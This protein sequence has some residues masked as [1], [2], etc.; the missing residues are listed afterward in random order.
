M[1]WFKRLF[2]AGHAT[3]KTHPSP[4]LAPQQPD[5]PVKPR[6]AHAQ[7]SVDVRRHFYNETG[8]Q[9]YGSFFRLWEGWATAGHVLS[10]ASNLLP[11]FCQGPQ[12]SQ[13]D[14]HSWPDGLDGALIGCA[15]PSV[16]PAPP[17]IGQS[18]IVQGY[19]AGSRH[20]EQRRASAY[21]ERQPGVWIAHII[22]PDGA[23]HAS[24]TAPPSA[25]PQLSVQCTTAAAAPPTSPCPV[26][27]A[28]P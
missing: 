5:S 28:D 25:S 15:L 20:L 18:L 16:P 8:F 6:P 1:S 14:V 21:F 7:T 19:P 11:D 10:E 12:G 17:R 24:Q 27:R 26:D 2:G 9:T 3:H 4:D 13:C 22:T 23:D